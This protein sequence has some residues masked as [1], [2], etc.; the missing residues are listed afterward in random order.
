LAKNHSV[1]FVSVNYRR[2]VLGFLSLDA[3]SK[4]AYPST[5][6]NYGLGDIVSALQW[7]KLNINHFG[8]HP[9]KVTL[10]GRGSGATLVTA[11]TATA[12]TRDLIKRVWVSNG[13]GIFEDKSLEQA[14]KENQVKHLRKEIF[15]L[16][17]NYSCFFTID[18]LS[19][20]F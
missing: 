19:S 8:G 2:G 14:N 11:L 10:L 3:L 12:K 9:S 18:N 20:V 7:I 16:D 17:I 5:S 1:V 13:A 15:S 4:R 6:G